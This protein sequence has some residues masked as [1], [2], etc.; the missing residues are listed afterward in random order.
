MCP[1]EEVYNID[2]NSLNENVLIPVPPVNSS[3][4][5]V[6]CLKVGMGESVEEKN[7]VEKKK[8]KRS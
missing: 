8:K 4:G 3:Q 7:K 2:H 5:V 1:S 6:S